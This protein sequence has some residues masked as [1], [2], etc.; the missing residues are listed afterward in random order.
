MHDIPIATVAAVLLLV[1]ASAF[2]SASETAIT[3]AS[4]ARMYQLERAGNRRARLVNRLSEHRE[5]VIGAILLGNNAVN[6]LASA[7]A[8][9]ALIQMFGDAGVVYATIAMTLLILVFGEVMPKTYALH[10]S[11]GV[12]L[13]ASRPLWPLVRLLSPVTH[14]LLVAIRGVFGLFGVRIA[15]EKELAATPEELRGMIELHRGEGATVRQERAMLRSVLDLDEVGVAQVMRHRRDTMTI[16]ADLGARA[17]VEQVVAS[18]YSRIPL[19]RDD[20]DNIIGVLHARAVLR[21]VWSHQGGVETLD[22]AGMAAEPWFIPESTSLLRQLQSFR[23]RREH[24]ALVVDEYGSL[25]GHVTLEDILEE[26][27]GDIADEHDIVPIGVRPQRDGSYLVDGSVTVR[28]LNRLFEWDLP[29][30]VAATVAG[31]VIHQARIIPEVNQTFIFHGFRFEVLRRQRN[32][33]TS[34]RVTPPAEAAAESVRSRA[35]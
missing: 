31:L 21:A 30:D 4:R 26:I 18:P 19:W 16:D 20:P 5:R 23:Q 33:I 32:Q 34:V 13:A 12:A 27:V 14:T 8:T 7:L 29:D 9:S 24:F 22:V 1:G 2:F 28:D 11:D 17:I 25:M 3:A 10:H 15:T 6:I 35:R